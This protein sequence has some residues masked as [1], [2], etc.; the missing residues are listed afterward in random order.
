MPGTS[1]TLV[2][3]LPYDEGKKKKKKPEVSRFYSCIT[4]SLN[5]VLAN[6]TNRSEGNYRRSSKIFKSYA[7][8]QKLCTQ[9]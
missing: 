9:I 7:I 5:G 4:A 6:L 2:L 8:S 3:L 1:S